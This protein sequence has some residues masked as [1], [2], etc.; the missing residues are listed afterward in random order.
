MCKGI[1]V[2]MAATPNLICFLVIQGEMK[3][4]CTF[5]VNRFRCNH[6]YIFCVRC[7]SVAGESLYGARLKR[8][9]E[10]A[11]IKARYKWEAE[12]QTSGSLLMQ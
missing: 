8:G 2:K 1:V 7:R 9:E 10:M 12:G 11:E 3:R 4:Q 6:C 5:T